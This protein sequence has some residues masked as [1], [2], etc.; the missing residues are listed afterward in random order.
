MYVYP[1]VYLQEI[2]ARVTPIDGVPTSSAAAEQRYPGVYLQELATHPTPIP[3]V[4]TQNR[5]HHHAT[6]PGHFWPFVV[7]R[8]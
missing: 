4:G 2:P 3:G 6:R 5:S 8:F 1:G 7:A